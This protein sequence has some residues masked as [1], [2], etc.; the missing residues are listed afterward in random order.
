MRPLYPSSFET[1]GF[2]QLRRAPQ[3]EVFGKHNNRWHVKDE[4][5]LVIT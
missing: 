2:A 5:V 4:A 1:P 3:D